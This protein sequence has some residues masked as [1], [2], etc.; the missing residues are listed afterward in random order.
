MMSS[1]VRPG[2]IAMNRCLVFP[3][4]LW[5]QWLL[6]GDKLPWVNHASPPRFPGRSGPPRLIAAPLG[7]KRTD[8]DRREAPLSPA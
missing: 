1:N 3:P 2:F 8:K 7:I 4:I 6:W 5:P